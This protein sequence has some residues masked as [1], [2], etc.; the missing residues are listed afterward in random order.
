MKRCGIGGMR[1]CGI[2]K[3]EEMRN[4]QSKADGE[5]QCDFILRRK[6]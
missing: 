2:E 6:E 5:N 1:R 3:N 4:C